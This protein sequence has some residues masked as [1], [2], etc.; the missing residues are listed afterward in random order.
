MKS[1]KRTVYLLLLIVVLKINPIYGQTYMFVGKLGQAPTWKR[2]EKY[3]GD[4]SVCILND[5]KEFKNKHIGFSHERDN[6][7]GMEKNEYKFVEIRTNYIENIKYKQI[8]SGMNYAEVM[9]VRTPY[10]KIVDTKETWYFFEGP[11]ITFKDGIVE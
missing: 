8:L 2:A 11:E 1:L 10:Y 3:Y 9:A 4:Y 7:R 5:C 6:D